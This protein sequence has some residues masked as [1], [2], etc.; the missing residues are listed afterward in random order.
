[1]PNILVVGG[2][3]YIGS[4]MVLQLQAAGYRAVVLDDFSSGH[5]HAG[6][7]VETIHGNLGDP[8]LLDR[9]FK[10]YQLHA[11]M[12]FAAFIQV[13]ESVQEPAKYYHNNVANTLVL[14]DKMRE[15][16]INKFIFSSTA[17]IFGEP[18]YVPIDE[19]HPKTPLNPY[20]RT[21][22]ILEQILQDYDVAYGL[23]S[24]CLRYFNACGADPAGRAGECHEPETHLVPLV[25]QAASGKRD[26]IKVFGRDYDTPD[27]TCLRDYIHV[28]DLCQ[29]HLLALESLLKGSVSAQYNLGNGNG[30]SVQEVID[31]AKQVTQ[32]EIKIIDAPRRA[33][34]P[35]RLI[36]D[37]SKAKKE[38]GWKTQYADLATIIEHAWAWE[39][40]SAPK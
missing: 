28:S 36:A 18:Q 20:G 34:D 1:M 13:G 12:H 9:I 38:L 7:Q 39:S 22:W 14:L 21:K 17:A 3:G 10:H 33:G 25:L 15:H 24:I 29:A 11:V 30:F 6:V 37:S 26:S 19:N 40:R 2:A 31:V 23:K 27:G 5:T 8:V 35:A 16:H 4:H 32:R